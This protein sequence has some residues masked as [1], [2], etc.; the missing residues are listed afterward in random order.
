MRHLATAEGPLGAGA[1]MPRGYGMLGGM[2]VGRAGVA[3]SDG[4]PRFARP[5]G[6][7]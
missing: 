1:A 3:T 5:S 7:Y 4:E 2:K 6:M